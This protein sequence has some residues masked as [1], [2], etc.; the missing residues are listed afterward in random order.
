[1][2]SSPVAG[3][4]T[5]IPGSTPSFVRRWS[6]QELQ[7]ADIR[8]LKHAQLKAT[9]LPTWNALVQSGNAPSLMSDALDRLNALILRLESA[10]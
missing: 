9:D 6:L 4:I 2:V 10:V 1:M 8:R 3:H 7:C 5:V